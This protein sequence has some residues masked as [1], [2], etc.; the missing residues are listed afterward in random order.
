LSREQRSSGRLIRKL[1]AAVVLVPLALIIIAFAVANRQVVTVSLDPFNA[2]RPAASLSVPLF[3]LVLG[4][5][6]AGVMIGGLAAWLSHGH[7]RR[8]AR[9]FEREVAALRA[10]LAS[11]RRPAGGGAGLPEMAKPPERLRLKPPV[12]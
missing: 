12:Q 1:V 2:A 7:W 3:V 9:R 10:E 5:L 6:I 8:A 11:L 4:L